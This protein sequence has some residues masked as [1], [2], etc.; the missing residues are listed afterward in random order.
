[1][2]ICQ[3]IYQ[4]K[5]KKDI[6]I[7]RDDLYPFLGGGN[8]GRKI[9][10]IGKEILTQAYDAV[11]TTGGIQSN[12][13]RATAVFCAQYKLQCTLV[14]HGDKDKFLKDSGNAKIMRMSGANI[15]FVEQAKDIGPTMDQS[16]GQYE[17][18][19]LKPYYLW[20]GGHNLQGGKAYIDAVQQL[21]P[22]LLI[23]YLF[24]AC[25]TGSTQ[26]GIMAGLSKRNITSQVIGIS[27]ARTKQ[28]AEEHVYNFYN[29]LCDN[30]S[31]ERRHETIVLDDYLCGGYEEY[32]DE[33]KKISDDSILDYGFALDTTYSGK[34]FW[35]MQQYIL[36]HSLQGN[37]VFWHTGGIFNF[38]A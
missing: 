35:G 32:N 15:I 19:G 22:G 12:H 18:I 20:G 28:S 26:A 21:N 11:V 2:I 5:L 24:V 16:M 8:K 9:D 7:I 23:D 37:I 30:F 34:A 3:K 10:S 13:C 36:K 29:Q 4:A 25:G 14:L 17:D 27:V 38:L 1:M 33:L 6:T 31:I